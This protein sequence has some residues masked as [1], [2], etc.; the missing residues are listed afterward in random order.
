MNSNYKKNLEI[1]IS[2]LWQL[3]LKSLIERSAYVMFIDIHRSTGEGMTK[4]WCKIE[5][6][7]TKNRAL[8]YLH[9]GVIAI[10]TLVNPCSRSDCW[11]GNCHLSLATT[12]DNM[13]LFNKKA[14]NA[15]SFPDRASPTLI[16]SLGPIQL[17]LLRG[18]QDLWY[19]FTFWV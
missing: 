19:R 16:V 9:I 6:L 1:L 17:W 5:L 18:G 7:M 10:M 14:G 3:F 15:A 13:S 4:V 2:L 11:S 12:D 8:P